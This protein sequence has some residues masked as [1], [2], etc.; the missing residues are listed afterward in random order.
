MWRVLPE[1]DEKGAMQFASRFKKY[2]EEIP[3]EAE[4]QSFYITISIGVAT[5]KP[6]GKERE[7]ST[8]MME[9]LINQSEKAM[10]KAKEKG[11]NRVELFSV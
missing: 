7:S 8:K 2:V 10:L 6:D 1:T 3:V 9:E 5:V 11:G 4:Y